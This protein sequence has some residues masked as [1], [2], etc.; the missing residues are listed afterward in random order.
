MQYYNTKKKKKYKKIMYTSKPL[1]RG[2][3]S[4]KATTGT[5]PVLTDLTQMCRRRR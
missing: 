5:T 2:D 3:I 4:T 1:S